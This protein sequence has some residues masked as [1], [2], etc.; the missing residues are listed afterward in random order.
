MCVFTVG[1]WMT[2]VIRV[3]GRGLRCRRLIVAV[4]AVTVVMVI[5]TAGS[6]SQCEQ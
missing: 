2:V 1:V 5:A 3:C 4:L 6:Q